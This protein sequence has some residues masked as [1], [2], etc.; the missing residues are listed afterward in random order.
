MRAGHKSRQRAFG[1]YMLAILVVTAAS[2]ANSANGL[3]M[4]SIEEASSWQ[5]IAIRMG[6]LAL[7]LAV[8]HFL[9]Q[10]NMAISSL[11]RLG[12]WSLFGAVLIGA[13][14]VAFIWSLSYTT[15]ADTMFTLSAVPFITALLGWLFLR[16]RVSLR[17]WAAMLAAL[18]G[19][20]IMLADGLGG[21]T[22]LGNL[23]ALFAA[24]AFSGFVVILRQGR[25]Q[26][27]LPM[28]FAGAVLSAVFS[29]AMAGFDLA[30]PARD[31]WIAF[32]WGAVLSSVMQVAFLFGSRHVQGAELTLIVL[33]EFILAPIWVWLV[34]AEHP[35]ALTVLG[36][37]LVISA[38][39]S[40]GIL[41]LREGRAVRSRP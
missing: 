26:N 32:G 40:R 34:F 5:I 11:L 10:R 39:G 14:N 30:V 24:C 13:V 25:R 41:A 27:M 7:A 16:E 9:Q 19:I 28:V 35:G 1:P 31:L 18:G 2:V 12:P 22:L 29:G 20:G 21:G 36:G 8:I 38:V 6:A 33:L 15:V 4:R 3:L 23:L 37:M 17:L